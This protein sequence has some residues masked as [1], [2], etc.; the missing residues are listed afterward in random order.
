LKTAFQAVR[1]LVAGYCEPKI[2][3]SINELG[4]LSDKRLVPRSTYQTPKGPA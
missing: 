1:E 3:G 2:G 4:D